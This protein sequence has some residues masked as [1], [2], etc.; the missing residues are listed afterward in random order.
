MNPSTPVVL[1]HGFATSSARTWGENGWLDL[2]AD[3]GRETVP[4][5]ILGHGTADKPHDPADEPEAER[6]PV[7]MGRVGMFRH[8]QVR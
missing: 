3:A 6:A 1:L 5:D 4:I 2:L 8:S 7:R